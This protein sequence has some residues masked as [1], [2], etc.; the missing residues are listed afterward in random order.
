MM[1]S[2]QMYRMLFGDAPVSDTRARI[3][4]RRDAD[5]SPEFSDELQKHLSYILGLGG[6]ETSPIDHLSGDSTSLL[7]D[8]LTASGLPTDGII[9]QLIR[10]NPKL[11][12]NPEIRRLLIRM[13]EAGGRH[14]MDRFPD[15]YD[16]HEIIE[17]LKVTCHIY[18]QQSFRLIGPSRPLDNI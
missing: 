11:L 4:P 12:L 2:L 5:M 13:V 15:I 10:D 14:E 3:R 6:T 17:L 7:D 18:K 1:L 8:L 16:V 9:Y